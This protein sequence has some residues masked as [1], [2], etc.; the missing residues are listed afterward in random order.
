MAIKLQSGKSLLGTRA[1]LFGARLGIDKRASSRVR[2]S[3]KT[4][5]EQKDFR[6]Y[7]RSTTQHG[8]G[9]GE[10]ETT[11]AAYSLAQP[12]TFWPLLTRHRGIYS[13]KKRRV[14]ERETGRVT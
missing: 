7:F 9:E 11:A 13:R 14:L 2:V 12:R 10:E 5:G 6:K 3:S 8:E 4:G 1:T